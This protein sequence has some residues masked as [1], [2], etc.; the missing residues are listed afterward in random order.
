MVTWISDLCSWFLSAEKIKNAKNGNKP[1][2]YIRLSA[3]TISTRAD[4][5]NLNLQ[6]GSERGM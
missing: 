3:D 6:N 1:Y 5:V 4:E 2:R